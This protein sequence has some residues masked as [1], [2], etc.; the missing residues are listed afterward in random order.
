[1]ATIYIDPDYGPGGD[2][3]EST[4]FDSW[5]DVTFAA[6]NT[7]LQRNGTEWSGEIQCF[8]A[9]TAAAP[10]VIGTYGDGPKA[11][12]NGSDA[13]KCIT[14]NT[15]GAYITIRGFELYSADTGVN[16]TLGAGTNVVVEDCVIHDCNIGVS[17]GGH[18]CAVRDC[19]IYTVNMD[20]VFVSGGENIRV[21]GNT[22]YDVSTTT[23]VGD[24]IQVADTASYN[25]S[26][27]TIEDNEITMT[28]PYKQAI[29]VQTALGSS[30]GGSIA[31]NVTR[32]VS[33]SVSGDTKN[34]YVGVPNVRVVGN[35]VTGGNGGIWCE[36]ANAVVSG[37][38]VIADDG[39]EY[40]ILVDESTS[41]IVNNTLIG[42][43]GVGIA[44]GGTTTR[45][46]H[47]NILR[48]PVIGL[49]KGASGTT[50]SYNA[51]F[52]VG[53][54]NASGTGDV[55]EDPLLDA[56]YRPRSDSPCVGAGIHIP[57]A[58]HFGGKRMSVVS[59]TIGA[60]GYYE[61]R[62]VADGRSVRMV[63]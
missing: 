33:G 48:G 16:K 18:N 1:M 12:I 56:S 50:D 41:Y 10:I 63:G 42:A 30:V 34:I 37:N 44:T 29:I 6:G 38:I 3:S 2:G 35:V 54:T 58:C 46:V 8:V 61:A 36:S 25:C 15:L 22:I 7:Y 45:F 4:P 31:R 52:D 17:I 43:M 26:G 21:T 20:G 39:M 32:H 13:G 53:T 5:A 14:I 60:H 62:S 51:Y 49:S 23:A 24:G 59:P 55:T 27:I 57:G 40:G 11:K 47:N 9:A 19:V 28:R